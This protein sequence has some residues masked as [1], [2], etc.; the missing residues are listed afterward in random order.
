VAGYPLKFLV[1][2]DFDGVLN[3]KVS[4][5]RFED[6][7]IFGLENVTALNHF[8]AQTGARIVV[9]STWRI[10]LSIEDLQE[11]LDRSRIWGEVV[12]KT[13]RLW[14]KR[15]FEIQQWLDE[16]PEWQDASFVILDDDSDMEHLLPRLVKV[17]NEVGLTVE[18][19]EEAI[20]MLRE[21]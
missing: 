18:N 21:P 13:P 16:N 7:R 10:G 15:G 3:S 14:K 11:I 8:L 1:F 2:L 5:I 19:A 17:N 4:S 12:G 9:S 6:P 20:K